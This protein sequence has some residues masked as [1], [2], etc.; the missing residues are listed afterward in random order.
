MTWQELRE[1]PLDHTV[2]Q[3]EK[4]ELLENYL[5]VDEDDELIIAMAFRGAYDYVMDAVGE[6]DE[7]EGTVDML[8]CALTQDFYDNRKLTESEQREKLRQRQAYQ[9]IILQLQLRYERKQ[10]V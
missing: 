1:A 9:S 2:Q 5:R 3:N 4:M 6:V 10:A 8:L 7:T